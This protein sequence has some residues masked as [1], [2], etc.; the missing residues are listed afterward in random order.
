MKIDYSEIPLPGRPYRL[1]ADWV[2]ERE[3]DLRTLTHSITE[4]RENPHVLREQELLT[5]RRVYRRGQTVYFLAVVALDKAEEPCPDYH[6]VAH[7]VSPTKSRAR[8]T[9]LRPVRAADWRMLREVFENLEVDVENPCF[10]WGSITLSPVEETGLWSTYLFVQTLNDVLPGTE[11]TVAARTIGG[12]LASNNFA[13]SGRVSNIA[14]GDMC[15]IDAVA[16]G[17][18]EVVIPSPVE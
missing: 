3:T 7:A 4:T 9:I 15:P 16:N 13:A 12:L 8:R 10:Y 6:V 14:Y 18:F 11:P 5:N 2:Y 1:G 17:D